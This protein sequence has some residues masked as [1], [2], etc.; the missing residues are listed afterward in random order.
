[1]RTKGTG[2]KITREKESAKEWKGERQMLSERLGA[3]I[4]FPEERP[5]ICPGT[6]S[7]Q[8]SLHFVL[9]SSHPTYRRSSKHKLLMD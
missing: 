8:E 2:E 1:M 6:P 4:G 3:L 9:D 7:C 5:K